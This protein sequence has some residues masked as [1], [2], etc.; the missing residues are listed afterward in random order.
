MLEE[1][2]FHRGLCYL[3]VLQQPI[4]LALP[5]LGGQA[6]AHNALLNQREVNSQSQQASQ[7]LAKSSCSRGTDFCCAPEEGL[8]CWRLQTLSSP[9]GTVQVLRHWTPYTESLFWN[10]AQQLPG[11][12]AFGSGQGSTTWHRAALLK[13]NSLFRL[14]TTPSTFIDEEIFL[15]PWCITGW[16]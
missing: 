5:P 16:Y 13:W 15:C 11:H 4:P 1:P 10:A 12:C 6:S 7:L 14:K 3:P 8:H 2:S 9:R